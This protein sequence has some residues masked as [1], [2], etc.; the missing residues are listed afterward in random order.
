MS[1]E[2]ARARASQNEA[3]LRDLA[4]SADRKQWSEVTL[5]APLR[6]TVWVEPKRP[7][8]GVPATDAPAANLQ[9]LLEVANV[10]E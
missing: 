5:V 1:I 9:R 3:R 4:K 10:R 2:W 8:H 7:R 6:V